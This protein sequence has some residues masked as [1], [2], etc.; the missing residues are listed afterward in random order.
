MKLEFHQL[1]RRHEHLRARNPQRQRQLLASLA[2]SGQQTPIVVV[3]VPDQPDRYLVIDGYKRIAALQQLGRDTVEAVVWPMN[4]VQAL[5]LDRS[6]HWSE[7]ESALEEGWLLAELEQRFGYGLEELARQ[8]DRSVSWVSRR[9][10]L[11]E[12][13]PDSVQQQVRAGEI[14]AQVA[15]KYL[16]PVAR[17]SL[18]D[19]QQ[20]A[21]AFARHKFTSRQAG[22][23][24][25]AWREAPP[26]I[27]QRLLEQPQLFLKAQRETEPQAAGSPLQ[28]LLRDLE[29]IAAIAHRANRRVSRATSQFE[30]LDAEQSEQVRHQ[31][32]FARQELRRLAARIPQEAKPGKEQ[33]HVESK[34]ASHDSATTWSGSEE[35]RDR[36]PA[37]Y[38]SS[39]RAQGASLQLHPGADAP[40]CGEGR[41][42]SATDPGVVGPLQGES[43]TGP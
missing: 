24:Y 42:L 2:A 43:C 21:A 13:L 14:P 6:L 30:Q 37:G 19:C 10:A 40:A 36:A 5:V 16:V 34:S 9:L 11:V 41:T 26:Q 15:M 1:D 7:P 23:L 8:F 3:A 18:D 35:T 27:R 29:M 20:M 22:Q 32:D 17:G 31:L 39:E 28:E 12:L 25:A 38:L 33:E 4:E